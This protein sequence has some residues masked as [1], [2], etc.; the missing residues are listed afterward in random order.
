VQVSVSVSNKSLPI[1]PD[2]GWIEFD[3]S[4]DLQLVANTKMDLD[5]TVAF[6]DTAMLAEGWLARE[7]GR[8]IEEG[9]GWLPYIRGQQDVLIRM[10][11]LPDDTT[12][13]IVGDAERSSWQ[14][15]KP[16]TVPA[17][18]EKVGM[19][20]ADFPIPEGAKAVKF[21]VDQKQIQFDLPGLTPPELAEQ[22]VE[23]LSALDWKREKSGVM[24]DEY[25]LLSLSKDK[26]EIQ[27]RAR[28]GKPKG[29]S[30]IISGNGLLWGKP[31]P[32]RPVRLS[33]ETWLR[34]NRFEATLDRLEEFSAEMHKISE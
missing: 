34:R 28:A 8:H 32:T 16:R 20:A 13:I 14:L 9:K 25:V 30:V 27:I 7:A 4:T 12:R 24:S 2:A 15:Q 33:Y 29:S 11:S 31:L 6:Y 18:S 22:F 3:S 26:A 23:R 10:V 1:P 19:E 21:E 17:E 5:K